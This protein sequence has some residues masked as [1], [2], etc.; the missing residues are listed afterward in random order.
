[1]SPSS[2]VATE[3]VGAREGPPL[4]G[5]WLALLTFALSLA[6]FIEVLDSTVTNVAVPS[7]AGSLAVSNS[8]ATWVIS[9]YSVAAAIAVPLTGWLSQR[10]GEARLFVWSVLLFTLTSLLCGIAGNL[11]LLVLCRA[12]QGLTSG[13]MVPL[14]QAI[15]LRSFPPQRRVLALALWA[16]TVLLAPIFGP[17]L[18]GWIIDQF[19]WPWIFFINLPIGLF[20]FAACTALLRR[21]PP[22]LKQPPKDLIGIALLVVA[23]RALHG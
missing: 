17:V 5:A 15:L 23:V 16:M 3:D 2:G 20:A 13:P 4:R 9:S 19:S 7:I 8:Q 1:M 10:I 6:T 22:S 14:S 21:D 11:E 12:M 18:G